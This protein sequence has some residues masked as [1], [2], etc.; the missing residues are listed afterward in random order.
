MNVKERKEFQNRKIGPSANK[1]SGLGR[2][3]LKMGARG[4]SQFSVVTP[5][6]W[7]GDTVNEYVRTDLPRIAGEAV[8]KFGPD[9]VTYDQPKT[10]DSCSQDTIRQAF[11]RLVKR[12][13]GINVNKLRSLV[14][15]EMKK[16]VDDYDVPKDILFDHCGHSEQISSKHHANPPNT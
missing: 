14:E 2:R 15:T 4:E 3:A 1:T 16:K 9:A 12:V 5:L 10:N 13:S 6:P 11:G 7:L 8:R